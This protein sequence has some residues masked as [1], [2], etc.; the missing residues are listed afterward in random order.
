[1]SRAKQMSLPI[2]ADKRAKPTN[3]Y[4]VTPSL[5]RPIDLFGPYR[6]RAQDEMKAALCA[7]R[8]ARKKMGVPSSFD[9]EDYDVEVWSEEV[10]REWLVEKIKESVDVRGERVEVARKRHYDLS[11]DE[12]ELTASRIM[13][14]LVLKKW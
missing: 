8:I 14:G 4:F 1:M 11:D 13:K 5:P 6:I 7:F 12:L 2:D 3:L 10:E 9:E